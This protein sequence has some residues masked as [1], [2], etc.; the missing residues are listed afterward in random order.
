MKHSGIS[1]TVATRRAPDLEVVHC[2][3]VHTDGSICSQA[4]APKYSCNVRQPIADR[5]AQPGA[6]CGLMTRGFPSSG[7]GSLH[8]FTSGTATKPV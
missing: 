2:V 6:P 8:I 3:V 4:H 1:C 5:I 7:C